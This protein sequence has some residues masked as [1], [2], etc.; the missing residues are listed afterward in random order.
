MARKT[1]DIKNQ[2]TQSFISNN[3]VIELYGLDPERSFDEQFSILSFEN[4]LFN[5][6]TLI[7]WTL[8]ALFDVHKKEV[9]DTLT[10]KKPHTLRWYRNKVRDFQYG[11]DLIEDTDVFDNGSET[12][13]TIEASKIIKYAAVTESTTESR[14][15]V[16]VATEING[17]LSPISEAVYIALIAYLEEIKDAGVKITVI[18]YLPDI[19]RLQ[20]IIYYDPLLLTADGVSILTGR[21]PV[22][23]ALQEFMKELPFNGKLILASLVDKLQL[24]EGVRIPHLVNAQSKWIDSNGITY[25]NF[26]NIA[27]QKIPIS[28]YFQ[29]ENFDNISYVAYS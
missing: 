1:D 6:F 13:E 27:V 10:E 11:F 24:T 9:A 20:Q 8:E 17:I 22:E 15:I 2:I 21:K 19:L 3:R 28:G 5:V 7:I 29:I 23:D 4:Q 18:N 12:T 16:K 25:G 26:E 14:L